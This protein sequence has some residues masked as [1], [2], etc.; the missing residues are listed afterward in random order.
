MPDSSSPYL[1]RCGSARIVPATVTG[2]IDVRI[3]ICSDEDDEGVERYVTI[4]GQIQLLTPA[5]T[6][7]VAGELMDAA[8]E[9]EAALGKLYEADAS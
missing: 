2:S 1:H 8:D 4:S 9:L 3:D 7:A 5:A 6:R